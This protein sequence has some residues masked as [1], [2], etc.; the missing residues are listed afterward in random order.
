M[1]KVFWPGNWINCVLGLRIFDGMMKRA[2]LENLGKDA[3]KI[4]TPNIM[5]KPSFETYI[6]DEPE[7]L[8]SPYNI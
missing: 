5:N 8:P 7:I 1:E 4:S 2:G 6:L 3:K